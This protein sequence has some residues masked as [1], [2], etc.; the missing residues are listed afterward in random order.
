MIS[1]VKPITT[2]KGEAMAFARL[3]DLEGGVEVVI[4]PNVYQE[5]R[6]LLVEDNL[7]LVAGR[8]DQKGEGETKLIA[9]TITPFEVDP[10][11]EEERLT[12]RVDVARLRRVP[13]DNLRQVLVDHRGD[14]PVVMLMD[15]DDGQERYRFGTEYMVDARDGSLHAS[16]ASL[17]GEGCVVR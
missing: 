14:A 7:V 1:M 8:I 11:A 3:D 12:I 15:T 16:L 5:A 10:D 4:V 9:R 13:L 2:K 17:F 6:D